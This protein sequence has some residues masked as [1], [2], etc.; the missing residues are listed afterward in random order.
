MGDSRQTAASSIKVTIAHADG[1]APDAPAAE[2]RQHGAAGQYAWLD[3][4]GSAAQADGAAF[5]PLG[6]RLRRACAGI[7]IL[8]LKRRALL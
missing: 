4:R 3:I 8:W 5:L 6:V 1:L 2:L 7:T